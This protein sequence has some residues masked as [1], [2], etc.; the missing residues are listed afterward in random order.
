MESEKSGAM[1]SEKN[2]F[3]A[4]NL[5]KYVITG[6][7]WHYVGTLRDPAAGKFETFLLCPGLEI[8]FVRIHTDTWP[9]PELSDG[10][11]LLIINICLS[12]RCEVTLSGEQS[13]I[14]SSAEF[15]FGSQTAIKDFYYPGGI[16]EGLEIFLDQSVLTR[17]SGNFLSFSGISLPLLRSRYRCDEN[18]YVSNCPEDVL[19]AA[20][21]IWQLCQSEDI[22]GIRL[23]TALLLHAMQNSEI[24][25]ANV[26]YLTH[27]QVM[28]A[29]SAQRD[30]TADLSVRIPAA[31]F[32]EKFNI[33]ESSFLLYFKSVFGETY[34]KF[35][36]RQRIEQARKLLTHSDMKIG[37][38]CRLIGYENQGKFART[39]QK[40]SGSTPL[41]Y[42]RESRTDSAR[43]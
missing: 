26:V 33:S 43:E 23:F 8:S 16:Y 38:I 15:S 22:G 36:Q 9:F 13:V 31:Q 14:L 40:W 25:P 12:G 17:D 34:R 6:N 19:R 35:M 28:I 41:E 2:S 7:S 30:A 18:L 21:Q 24:K 10:S 27:S 1:G 29:K 37:D 11:N 20:S 4:A 3:A 39:F 42:R 5:S 32:A